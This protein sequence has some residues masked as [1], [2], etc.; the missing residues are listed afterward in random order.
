MDQVLIAVISH[1]CRARDRRKGR[2]ASVRDTSIMNDH[3]LRVFDGI[4]MDKGYIIGFKPGSLYIYY[5]YLRLAHNKWLINKSLTE[6]DRYSH[7]TTQHI[8]KFQKSGLVH[9]A[10]EGSRPVFSNYRI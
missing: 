3:M 8:S 7:Q 4:S 10:D 5:S 1:K 2:W 9:V 6:I